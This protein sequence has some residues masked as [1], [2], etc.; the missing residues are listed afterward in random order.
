MLEFQLL[1]LLLVADTAVISS[2]LIHNQIRLL[3]KVELVTSTCYF[4][5]TRIQSRK[6]L[7]KHSQKSDFEET[8]RKYPVFLR[9]DGGKPDPELAAT[10]LSGLDAKKATEVLHRFRT[11]GVKQGS[12]KWQRRQD[13]V[14]EVRRVLS[15]LDAALASEVDSLLARKRR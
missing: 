2:S 7:L 15:T 9:L 12:E 1:P 3:T 14:E 5:N 8:R 11:K 4:R 10:L 13:A 6:S